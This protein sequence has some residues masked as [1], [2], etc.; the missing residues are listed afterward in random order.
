MQEGVDIHSQ[1][2]AWK[3]AE[4]SDPVRAAVWQGTEGPCASHDHLSC[5]EVTR[6]SLHQVWEGG[7]PSRRSE[8]HF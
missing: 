3:Q 4:P 6:A 7:K 2:A 1:G 5:L 8:R